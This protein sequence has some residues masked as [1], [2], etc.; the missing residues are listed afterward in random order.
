MIMKSGFLNCRL[1]ESCHLKYRQLSLLFERKSGLYSP[2]FWIERRKSLGLFNSWVALDLKSVS[3]SFLRSYYRVSVCS[4]V[5]D[6]TE[7]LIRFVNCEFL[8]A[9]S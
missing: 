4:C 5:I 8:K 6:L 7:A 9:L 1:K 3:P 2:W